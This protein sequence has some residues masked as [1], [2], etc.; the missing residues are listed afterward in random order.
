MPIIERAYPN[1]PSSARRFASPFL[2][3]KQLELIFRVQ[4]CREP[5]TSSGFSPPAAPPSP[6]SV[7]LNVAPDDEEC[8]GLFWGYFMAFAILLARIVGAFCLSHSEML[9]T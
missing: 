5:P 1:T 7:L 6:P 3:Q 8:E 2:L 9:A 4:F